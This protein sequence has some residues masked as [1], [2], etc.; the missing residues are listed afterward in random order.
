VASLP[1]DA[2]EPETDPAA[3]LAGAIP[4]ANKTNSPA[5][6]SSF[7]SPLP[8]QTTSSSSAPY[9]SAT[10]SP[11]PYIGTYNN[12]LSFLEPEREDE[13]GPGNT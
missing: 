8:Y 2:S 4:S 12:P 13:S 6:S 1:V 7:C 10:S 5:G 11:N 9:L 3:W